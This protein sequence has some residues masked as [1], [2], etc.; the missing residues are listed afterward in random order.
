MI[1]S[2]GKDATQDLLTIGDLARKTGASVRSLRHYDARGLLACTRRANGYRAFAR[3]AVV[4]VRQI[5]RLLATGFS[6][7]E[8][9]AFPDCMR[10]IE[11][12]SA[13]PQTTGMQRKRLDLIERQIADLE[14]RRTRL[15]KMLTD[16]MTPPLEN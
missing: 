5:Q 6:L 11:G 12:A 4:Q 2:M 1:F 10:I 16:G 7:V 8:I 14:R 9:R 13:C 15:R 3:L